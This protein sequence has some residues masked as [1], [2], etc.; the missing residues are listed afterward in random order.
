MS[1]VWYVQRVHTVGGLMP[2]APCPAE[3]E[4]GS[5]PYL[6]DYVFYR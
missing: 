5:S 3:H 1:V 2:T 4:I 6:A